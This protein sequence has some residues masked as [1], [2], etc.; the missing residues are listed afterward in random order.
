MKDIKKFFCILIAV[1]CL[2][3]TIPVIAQPLYGDIMLVVEDSEGKALKNCDIKVYKLTDDKK[4]V[5]AFYHAGY[6]FAQIWDEAGN[7]KTSKNL[8]AYAAQNNIEGISVV[9]DNNGKANISLLGEGSYLVVCSSEWSKTFAPFICFIPTKI[10]GETY[11]NIMAY[12]KV[13]EDDDTPSGPSGSGGSSD[14]DVPVE[15][16]KPTIPVG[17]SIVPQE[18]DISEKPVDPEH[19]SG[20]SDEDAL[21]S[22][23]DSPALIPQTGALK[24]P[25]W[26]LCGVGVI[27]VLLGVADIWKKERD[28][29]E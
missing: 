22:L 13:S 1:A 25:V 27:F 20:Q 28:L 26:V 8:A 29:D 5:N 4:L 7:A 14:P 18:P 3:G 23:N 17:P 2:A 12:P 21:V 9:T 6:S 19:F 24:W 11:Y 10:A 16:N 15:P